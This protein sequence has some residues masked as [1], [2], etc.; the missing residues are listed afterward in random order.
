MDSTVLGPIVAD[1][2]TRFG[3]IAVF[4]LIFFKCA[5]VPLPGEITLVSAFIRRL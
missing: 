3:Y 2:V 4:L 1:L 5:G